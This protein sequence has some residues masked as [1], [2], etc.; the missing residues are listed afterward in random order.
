MLLFD[1]QNKH[2]YIVIFT[3]LKA[4]LWQSLSVDHS[5]INA[6]ST[7]HWSILQFMII[8]SKIAFSLR[9]FVA[10]DCLYVLAISNSVITSKTQSFIAHV[11]YV[12]WK[13]W[14]TLFNWLECKKQN[15][16][17]KLSNN[18]NTENKLT[19]NWCWLQDSS[20][21]LGQSTSFI[22]NIITGKKP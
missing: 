4:E 1:E 12:L 6:T 11:K 9:C 2:S 16:R 7:L 10:W 5:T 14:Y 3:V 22:I 21:L 13:T 18:K 20:G 17:N 15:Y 8:K 19:L